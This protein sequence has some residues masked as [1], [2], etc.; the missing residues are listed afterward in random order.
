MHHLLPEFVAGA[1]KDLLMTRVTILILVSL[2]SLFATDVVTLRDGSRR[3]GT[4]VSSTGREIVFDEENGARQRY[5]VTQVKSIEFD[6]SGGSRTSGIYADPPPSR[7][8][9]ASSTSR[10]IPAGT[11]MAVRTNEAIQS[12]SAAEGRGSGQR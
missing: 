8:A 4:L 2:S 12:E 9:A 6:A 7:P 5:S 10:T 1:N 3:Y 11:E